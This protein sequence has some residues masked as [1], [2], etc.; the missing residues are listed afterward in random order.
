[1]NPFPITANLLQ[2]VAVRVG[3]VPRGS[4]MLLIGKLSLPLQML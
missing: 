4:R 2:S 1:M 3:D